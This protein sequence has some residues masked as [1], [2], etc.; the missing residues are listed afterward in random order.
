[1]FS[2]ILRRGIHTSSS[3]IITAVCPGQ[4]NVSPYIFKSIHNEIINNKASKYI[5]L[6]KHSQSIIPE[7]P[8]SE[9]FTNPTFPTNSS[10]QLE[11]TEFVQPLVLLSTYMNYLIFQDKFNYNLN[12]INYFLGH[13]LGELSALVIQDVISLEDGLRI[14]YE[15]G[16]L[17]NLAMKQHSSKEDWS[18][19]ALIFKPRD[20]ASILKICKDDIKFNISNINGYDQ[21]VISGSKSE[22]NEKLS[23]LESIQNELIKL[24]QWKSKIRKVWLKTKIPAHHPIFEDIQEELKSLITL[25]SENLYVPI[26]CNLNGLVVMKNSQRV[27]DNFVNATSKPVQFVKCLETIINTHDLKDENV[28]KF[29]NVSDVT[30]G[31]V[32]RFFKDNDKVQ[33]FD[34]IETMK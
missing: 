27:V 32:N 4:G 1:M 33:V 12:H 34:L 31:L 25:K 21:I 20:F 14:S 22:L 2:K 19:V 23:K 11:N 6:L 15:R 16:R 7:V 10:L 24:K 8:I 9:Y 30:Y 13:S 3:E 29:L 26:V 5:E 28:Y 18:M 17:M